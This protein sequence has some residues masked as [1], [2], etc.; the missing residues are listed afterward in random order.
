[1]RSSQL[2]SS[3]RFS[4]W[5]NMRDAD[6][7]SDSTAAESSEEAL[8]AHDETSA[9]IVEVLESPA[10]GSASNARPDE[11]TQ[12][13]EIEC[14][15]AELHLTSVG[16]ALHQSGKCKPCAWIL[17]PQG[18]MNGKACKHCHSCDP[19]ELKQ[20]KRNKLAALKMQNRT[21]SE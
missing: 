18:C 10:N 7:A 16:A 14:S 21:T 19:T 15:I 8:P 2:S 9:E 20:R 11:M 4:L 12:S 13:A 5:Q 1:M 6:R 3:M 17:K